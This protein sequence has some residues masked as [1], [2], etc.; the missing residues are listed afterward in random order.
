MHIII[1]VSKNIQVQWL[2]VL[3]NIISPD[4]PGQINTKN[5][6]SINITNVVNALKKKTGVKTFG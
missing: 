6:T 5:I 2:S 4:I 1:F 3:F